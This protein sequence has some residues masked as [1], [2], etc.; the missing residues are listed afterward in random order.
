MFAKLFTGVP[1]TGFEKAA[2][3]AGLAAGLLGGLSFIDEAA[4]IS[5]K[6]ARHLDNIDVVDV[7]KAGR[8]LSHVDELAGAAKAGRI[9]DELTDVAGLGRHIDEALDAATSTRLRN[10]DAFTGGSQA[11]RSA[12]EV[13]ASLRNQ[14]GQ[15]ALSRRLNGG[16]TA[17]TRLRNLD[18][19]TD[20]NQAARQGDELRTALTNNR[21][22]ATL[23]E[24]RLATRAWKRAG[25]DLND[26]AVRQAIRN[27]EFPAI[28]GGSGKFD[29]PRRPGFTKEESRFID[30]AL[31]GDK[32]NL[33]DKIICFSASMCQEENIITGFHMEDFHEPGKL[34]FDP[35]F[36]L[37][38]QLGKELQPDDL[39][40]GDLLVFHGSKVNDRVLQGTEDLPSH[41]TRVLTGGQNPLL[42][43]KGGFTPFAE[44]YLDEVVKMHEPYFIRVFRRQKL[45]Q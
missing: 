25:A 45:S 7:A 18:N 30:D 11:T 42:F 16:D 21:A 43:D 9:A 29:T 3:T 32:R 39:R 13:R 17:E 34:D 2:I 12:D 19:F 8:G 1:L 5:A 20:G 35:N 10:L 40:E 4:E 6:M 26:P 24:R 36:Q 33:K 28:R 23:R 27:G 38:G 41:A 31:D 44:R 22:G 37:Q 14:S 15:G